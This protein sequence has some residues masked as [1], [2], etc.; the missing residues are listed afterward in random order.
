MAAGVEVGVGATSGAALG[1][2]AGA[3]LN[4]GSGRRRGCGERA[5]ADGRRRRRE[6]REWI[7]GKVA[8]GRTNPVVKSEVAVAR[9]GKALLL[10]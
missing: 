10:P 4:L 1:S 9:S 3:A 7:W 6:W 8:W 2:E 5:A